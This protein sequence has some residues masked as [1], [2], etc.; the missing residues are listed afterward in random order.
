MCT[1]N[2]YGDIFDEDKGRMIAEGN[3]SHD[4]LRTY[5]LPTRWKPV[6]EPDLSVGA[7]TWVK[8]R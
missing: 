3:T 5:E 1:I 4:L 2:I 7:D 6:D 8:T